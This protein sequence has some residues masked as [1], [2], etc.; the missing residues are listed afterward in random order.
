MFF[1][2]FILYFI[3]TFTETIKKTDGQE[4]IC[5]IISPQWYIY[6]VVWKTLIHSYQ[7]KPKNLHPS[8]QHPVT[9]NRG[10]ST[11]DLCVGSPELTQAMLSTTL[12]SFR[13]P[14]NLNRDHGTVILDFDSRQL[15]SHH[16][17]LTL[18]KHTQGVNSHA[19]PT[20]NKFC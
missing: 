12:F 18:Y 4:F 11:N 5:F 10:N 15:F 19:Q 20:V 2:K 17:H 6:L 8:S 16:H 9:Y 13:Q 1:N 3:Y 14:A 7:R